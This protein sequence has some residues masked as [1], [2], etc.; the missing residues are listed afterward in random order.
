MLPD[1]PAWLSTELRAV[2]DATI[3][4]APPELLTTIDDR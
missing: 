4:A 1:P 3:A 2:L